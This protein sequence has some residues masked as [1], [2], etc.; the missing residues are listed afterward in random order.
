[1]KFR[2]IKNSRYKFALIIGLGL[3]FATPIF[4]QSKIVVSNAYNNLLWTDFVKEIESNYNISFFYEEE[5]IPNFKISVTDESVSLKVLLEENL[6]AF[7]ILVSIDRRGNVFLTKDISLNTNLPDEFFSSLIKEKLIDTKITSIRTEQNFIKTTSEYIAQTITVG[8]KE[9]GVNKTNVKVSGYARN[10]KTG[11][12]IIGATLMDKETGAGVATDEFGYFE[13]TLKKG[14][15]ILIV[16]SVNI[17]ESRIEVNVLSEGTLNVLLDDKIYL[18]DDVVISAQR[19]NKVKGTQMGVESLST[20]AVK[21]IPLVFGE[22]DVIKVALLLPG[23]QTVGEGAAGFNVRGSPTDQN[24]FYIN[25]VPIYN[26][27]HAS[28]F[29]SS[30][31]SDAIDEFT[32]Y[33]SNIPVKYGGRLSSIFDIKTK[34]GDQNKIKANGGISLITGRVLVEGPIKKDKSSFLIGMR[35]TYSDWA[36]DMMFKDKDIKDSKANFADFVS[37]FSFQLNKNN[38]L[39]VFF[40]YS[41]DK[42]DLVSTKTKYDYKNLGTSINWKHFFK[43]KN[44]FELSLAYSLYDFKK[45]ESEYEFSAFKQNYKLEHSEIKA[46]FNFKP[47]KQ[48]SIDAGINSTLYQVDRGSRLPLSHGSLVDEL[49]LGP[50]KGLESAIYLGDEWDVTPKFSLNAGIRYNLYASL[51]PQKVYQYAEG[52]PKVK[53]NI[54]DTLFFDNNKVAKTYGGLDFRAAAKYSISDDVSIKASFN[55]LHQYIYMLSNTISV[56]PDYTWK[57]VDYNTKPIIGDQ[58]SVGLF[59]NLSANAYEV[60]VEAYYKKVKNLVEIK[61]GQDFSLNKYIEQSTL[62]GDMT[63][64]G[65]EIMLKKNI[66]ALTGW[67]N[68]TYSHTNVLIDSE[69]AENRINYGESYPSNYDKPHALNLVANYDFSRRYRL[70]GNVVYST[71][72][73]ITY[74]TSFYYQNGTKILNY[75]KRNEYRI[76][77]YFRVD[78]SFTIEGNLQKRKMAHGSWTIS[79]YNVLGT[80][81]PYSIYFKQEDNKIKGYKLSIFGAPIFSLTYNFKLGNYDN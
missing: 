72:R 19:H 23:V 39:N 21:N 11:E 45:E 44:T 76:P 77:D 66:G 71:G 37:N 6:G 50:E 52:F 53:S 65:I 13:L 81:N 41:Y 32:L 79:I 63:A 36:I 12:A 60:S 27:S 67:I 70:S 61:D 33:K 26:T 17:S 58:F 4:S 57:L 2:Q 43:Q 18:L 29:F 54:Q 42:M 59:S 51:G 69:F 35:S 20:K 14:K 46:N 48:H 3:L 47:N 40:Y 75:S 38:L 30:F 78:L 10:S 5:N 16:N 74:P 8:T 24:L 49:H 62:Q 7:N 31:N 15:H 56:S 22:K 34:Q 64:Y 9:K 73:P 80:K 25:N 55:R 28:G 68:Y 1:M